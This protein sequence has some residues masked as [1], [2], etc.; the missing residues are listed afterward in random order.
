MSNNHAFIQKV[1][2]LLS[3]IDQDPTLSKS[4]ELANEIIKLLGITD[5]QSVESSLE[6]SLALPNADRYDSWF[7]P[8]PI[9]KSARSCFELI[10][11]DLIQA[12]F[13]WLK[14]RSR[15]FIAGSVHFTPNFEDED[16]THNERYKVG[17]DFFLSP[18]GKSLQIVLSNRGN[19]RIV[20][21]YKKINNTQVDIFTKWENVTGL[22]T[23]EAVHTTLWESFKLKVVNEKFYAEI[24][25]N[26]ILLTQHLSSIGKEKESSKLFA[27]RLLG[28]LLFCWF[29]RK[30]G[31][32]DE[33]IGYFNTAG[34]GST[35]YYRNSLER[36][37][38]LTL[39]TPI[40]ERDELQRK[41][42]K[43]LFSDLTR[44]KQQGLFRIDEKTPYLN[45]GLFEPHENDWYKDESLTFPEGFFISL[46]N[47]FE[48][49][50][51]TTDESTPE[52][53][54]IAID[55]EMLGRVFESL[56]ASQ[57]DET[58][59]Q[60]RKAKG[61][62]YT[63]REIV[64]YMCKE[65]LRNYL[66]S[67]V[68]E[69][70]NI[71]LA[72]DGLLDI[73]D[74]EWAKSVANSRRDTVKTY[75][76]YII[77]SLDV[78]KILDPA[79]GSGAFPMGMLQLL[80]KTYERLESRFDA[81][82]T[83][84]QIVQNNIFG[85]DIE[86]IAVEIARLRAWLSLIVDEED[87]RNVAPLPN[88]EFKFVCANSL[89]PLESGDQQNIFA[90]N[91]LSNKL[92]DIKEYYFNTRSPKKKKKLQA[93]YYTLTK[94]DQQIIGGEDIR[95]KQL[96]SFNPFKNLNP[97]EFLDLDQMFGI[98]KEFDIIISNPPWDKFKPLDPEFF[99]NYVHNYRE[100][101]KDE[102]KLLREDLLKN[103]AIDQAYKLY[104][105]KFKNDS[106]IFKKTYTLQ[107]SSDINL[108]K[109]FLEFAYRNSQIT[110][111]LIP[112][113]IVVDEGSYQLRN[114]F[115]NNKN[116]DL[117]I[118]LNNKNGLFAAIDNNQKFVIIQINKKVKSD[119]IRVN[120]WLDRFDNFQNKRLLRISSTFYESVDSNKTILLDEDGRG[121]QLIQKLL[122]NNNLTS[123]V[124]AN[125]DYWGE[126]HVTNNSDYF[127]DISGKIKLFSGKAIDQYDCMAKSWIEK[128]GR[129]S[130][131]KRVEFPKHNYRT[132]YYVNDVPDRIYQHHQK[133][134]GDYRIV[135]QT[136]TGA[137]N[138][139]RTLYAAVLPKK[140]LT[141]NS[142]GNIYLGKNDLELF[143]Y[144]GIF[145]SFI[146]DW[147]ARLR[148]ATNLNKFIL[149]TLL[150]PKFDNVD[151]Q[152]KIKLIEASIKLS[153]VSEDFNSI[154]QKLFNKN[155]DQVL[156]IKSEDRQKLKNE[157][158]LMVAKIYNLK[159][160][161]F[162]YIL[163]SFPIVKDNIKIELIKK[164]TNHIND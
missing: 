164:F 108:Y 117:V 35:S 5:I 152:L 141:N 144:L 90:D 140:Y 62:F 55:P 42:Q 136:I 127:N 64:S 24:A 139:V 37:F 159:L 39:N 118:G 99:S 121:I 86:P 134:Q 135:I 2:E 123:L 23:Q 147:Q 145:N 161:E 104:L 57:I 30:K 107:G 65:S 78:V 69:D 17:I 6:S 58:G 89:L 101:S 76:A 21:L 36:L 105:D 109:V 148:V 137:I 46:Y 47:H 27:S 20:E 72:I 48:E 71:K 116:L 53:E 11:K 15:Q 98:K 60:A 111:F 1:N 83:K 13:Y 132:E 51:F 7:Q 33:S 45:G 85:V 19:L 125:Y 16:Y 155:Y 70:G 120:G 74:S 96:K 92:K 4:L 59:Q 124:E 68:V 54:Q 25:N 112:G 162:E 160:E 130:I 77:N 143:F 18:N 40:D 29:L 32:I 100:L 131:W 75:R 113:Q 156:I 49:F 10:D 91:E 157:I 14:K 63:P 133:V 129:S 102:Q 43:E 128:H 119:S 82:K 110:T 115:L 103:L 52:Y 9:F 73:P 142:L 26:F 87:S 149:D 56:L 122:S 61:T 67:S 93:D 114:E 12:K 88:L 31:I 106:L 94:S 79:C 28:R 8:H 150:V 151:K 34:I 66:Y 97:A 146:V 50:N 81:Y 163:G 3:S 153:A 154:T 44:E 80:I 22:S 138:N 158:D 95:T 41:T 38:F 84:L 126:Y